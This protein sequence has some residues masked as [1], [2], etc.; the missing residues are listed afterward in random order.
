MNFFFLKKNKGKYK[1]KRKYKKDIEPHEVFLDK[2]A[3]KKE[4]KMDVSEKK[5]EVPISEKINYNLLLT[6]IVIIGIF[7]L[8]TF[9][10]Q[11]I[12]GKKYSVLSENNKT[13]ISLITPERGI[14]YD[15]NKKQLVQ[16]EPAF[17]LIF[18]KRDLLGS[19]FQGIKEIEKMAEIIGESSQKLKEKIDESKTEKVLILENISHQT[20]VLLKTKIKDFSAF[21]I[22]ENTVREYYSDLELSHLLG[23][24]GKINREE[25]QKKE[26]Y[27]I[28]DYIGKTGIERY[29]EDILRGIP[30]E[31]KT[32]KDAFGKERAKEEISSSIPGKS[33]ILHLD[34]ELQKRLTQELEKSLKRVGARKAAAVALDPRTGGVLGLVSLPSFNSNLLSQGVSQTELKQLQGDFLG[35]FFN[36]ITSGEYAT[37]ST[38]KPF[39][40]SAG[41]QENIISADD[42]INCQGVI[43]VRNPYYPDVEP[44]YYYYHDWKTHG[45]TDLRKAIAESCNVYFYRLGGGYRGFEG[46]GVERIKKYLSLFG[47]GRKTGVDLPD[48]KGGLVPDPEWKENYFKDP[49]LK[50]WRVGD[51][52]HLSIGQGNISATPLQVASAF[53]VIA[54]GG[55]LYQPQIVK[56]IMDSPLGSLNATSTNPNREIEEFSPQVIRSNFIDKENLKIVREGMREAVTY[57]S[58]VLLSTLPVKAAAKT[59]TAETPREKHYHHWV[60]VFAPYEDP[61][62]V[63]TILVEDVEGLQSATLPVAREVLNWYF[64]R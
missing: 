23:F 18:D 7:F 47:W 61:E 20:L 44:E 25:F 37:G 42:Q 17:D 49:Q 30:G 8:L 6:F 24:T 4:E 59:G 9:Y 22:E 35:P 14:I 62:I 15:R 51:T 56:E 60:V 41:L 31:T 13:R 57:G 12:Q 34:F 64:T 16:N 45:I 19:P 11:T 26:D 54:N 2:L 39:I 29:Y 10:F 27:S 21:E 63:L 50:I 3:Q 43:S 53:S 5:F 33:L 32:E 28:T 48:E 40:A 46:L 58:S 52:Y 38:I 36:R 1:V 55:T